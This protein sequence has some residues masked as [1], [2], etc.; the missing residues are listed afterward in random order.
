MT[1]VLP[2][3]Y[4]ALLFAILFKPSF[5]AAILSQVATSIR[6]SNVI[7]TQTTNSLQQQNSASLTASFIPPFLRNFYHKLSVNDN[8]WNIE[9]SM[10]V[11]KGLFDG[12]FF[13]EIS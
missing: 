5:E 2:V 13:I 12:K 1:S 8:L 4:S 11:F 3:L 7:A 9:P 6:N 10:Q